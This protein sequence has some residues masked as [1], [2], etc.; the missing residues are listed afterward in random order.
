MLIIELT[1]SECQEAARGARQLQS[2]ALAD[3]ANHANAS[4]REFFLEVAKTHEA[5][6]ERFENAR[7]QSDKWA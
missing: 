6:A 2:V 7:K 5:M 4:M 3:A 1:E